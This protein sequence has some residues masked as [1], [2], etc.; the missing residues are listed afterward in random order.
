MTLAAARPLPR[1]GL[2]GVLGRRVHRWTAVASVTS[3]GLLVLSAYLMPLGYM[4]ATSLKDGAQM[5]D[6]SAPL[7]P[8]KPATFTWDGQRYPVFSVPIGGGEGTRT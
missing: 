7:Y 2:R 3:L 6:A 4:A 5:S 8:A 1:F